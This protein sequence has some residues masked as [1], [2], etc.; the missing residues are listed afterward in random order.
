MYSHARLAFGLTVLIAVSIVAAGV[1][2]TRGYVFTTTGVYKGATL[3]VTNVPADTTIFVNNKQRGIV[4][5]DETTH[6]V[7][8]IGPGEQDVIVS[9]KTAWPW[10]SHFDFALHTA[11]TLNPI[12]V[13]RTPEQISITPAMTEYHK[14]ATTLFARTTIPTATH[15]AVSADGSGLL[16]AD[17]A[18]VY[19][20]AGGEPFTTFSGTSPIRMVA[21]YLDRNDAV[22]IATETQVFVIGINPTSPQNFLPIYSGTAPTFAFDGTYD[23][24]IYIKDSAASKDILLLNLGV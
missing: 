7:T 2:H 8:A 19:T 4:A 1:L 22:V 11:Y 15:P 5:K 21:W 17:G 23:K 6:A 18:T 12:L 10:V 16:W 24:R 13:P 9:Y 20:R 3:T 14:N